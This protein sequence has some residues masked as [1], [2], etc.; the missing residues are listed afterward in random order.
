[1][2][3]M[4]EDDHLTAFLNKHQNEIIDWV[5]ESTNTQFTDT[6]G[7]HVVLLYEN[8]LVRDNVTIDYINQGLIEN[9]LCVYASVNAYDRSNLSK[10]LDKIKGYK[11]NIV[12]RNLLIVNLRPFYDS[13][14]R[15]DLTPFEE[16]RT[17][18]Q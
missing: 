16:L 18:I 17:Q 10:V 4:A 13:A 12:K 11:E 1:V 14:L 15:G 8:N 3:P 6:S 7:K 5:N 9:Q 2:S